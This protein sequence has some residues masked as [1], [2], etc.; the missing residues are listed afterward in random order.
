MDL[1][2][3]YVL[4]CPI[5]MGIIDKAEVIGEMSYNHTGAIGLGFWEDNLAPWLQVRERTEK[6]YTN[7][8]IGVTCI[9][10]QCRA[11]V[12]THIHAVYCG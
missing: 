6:R 9:N 3:N 12:A 5:A 11:F 8:L 2:G 4:G 1:A 7:I 10:I